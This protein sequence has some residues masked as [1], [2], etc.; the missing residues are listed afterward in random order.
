LRRLGLAAAEQAYSAVAR[1]MNRTAVG[2][3]AAGAS[4]QPGGPSRNFGSG[5]FIDRGVVLTNHHVVQQAGA[6]WVTVYAPARADYQAV[7]A[8]HDQ[9]ADPALL[10]VA[11][12]VKPETDIVASSAKAAAATTSRVTSKMVKCMKPSF[13][14]TPPACESTDQ[15]VAERTP[16]ELLMVVAAHYSVAEELLRSNRDALEMIEMLH[17][18]CTPKPVDV[19]EA[20]PEPV[21]EPAPAPVVAEAIL[22]NSEPDRVMETLTELLTEPSAVAAKPGVIEPAFEPPSEPARPVEVVSE[23]R[24]P[25]YTGPEYL[26]PIYV[27]SDYA[28]PVESVDPEA[29]QAES[30]QDESSEGAT[31]GPRDRR[32]DARN[33]RF[34]VIRNL[35]LHGRLA[36]PEI[37]HHGD[38]QNK[39]RQSPNPGEK[40]GVAQPGGAFHGEAPARICVQK[41]SFP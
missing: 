30:A 19:V 23:S 20:Q 28:P 31:P 39:H 41:R 40:K 12:R 1:D 22:V 2:I 35:F 37:G 21:A 9:S 5:F 17:H 34:P 25:V 26:Q 11:G 4:A 33:C 16:D 36:D 13:I 29:A 3:T 8:V 27:Q 24:P 15:R 10:R 18:L 38:D 7:L 6:L 32:G 14:S